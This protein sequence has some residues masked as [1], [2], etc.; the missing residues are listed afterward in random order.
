[1]LYSPPRPQVN[2]R[3]L[4]K[5]LPQESHW[6]RLLYTKVCLQ[7]YSPNPK[8]NLLQLIS[9]SL[10]YQTAT[11]CYAAFAPLKMRYGTSRLAEDKLVVLPSL[12]FCFLLSVLFFLLALQTPKSTTV[13]GSHKCFECFQS[14]SPVCYS[15]YACF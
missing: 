4:P 2:S 8:L 3:K 11:V 1:M 10:F 13:Y 9:S 12:C 6:S 14:T 7:F 5:V 15:H